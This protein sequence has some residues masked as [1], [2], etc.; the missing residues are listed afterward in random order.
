MSLRSRES[1]QSSYDIGRN[2]CL[3]CSKKN[4]VE[5]KTEL[6][7]RHKRNLRLG[8]K[9]IKL[10]RIYFKIL[11]PNNY[12]FFWFQMCFMESISSSRNETL[13]VAGCRTKKVPY[14]HIPLILFHF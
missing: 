2:L 7:Y 12:I 14:D 8:P 6:V 9:H 4:E 3:V 1:T 11:H 13:F 5:V 10:F